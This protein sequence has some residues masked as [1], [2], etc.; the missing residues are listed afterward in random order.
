MVQ[1]AEADSHRAPLRAAGGTAGCGGQQGGKAGLG[2]ARRRPQTG[3][4]MPFGMC[5][6]PKVEAQ[7]WRAP[8]RVVTLLGLHFEGLRC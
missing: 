1:G 6:C 7:A 5:L 2:G 4:S 3:L 8:K